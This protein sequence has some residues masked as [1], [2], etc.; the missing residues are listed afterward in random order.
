MWQ[1]V[2]VCW[3]GGRGG[4]VVITLRAYTLAVWRFYP[5]FDRRLCGGLRLRNKSPRACGKLQLYQAVFWFYLFGGGLFTLQ[6]CRLLG[7]CFSLV[8]VECI[9]LYLYSVLISATK[10]YDPVSRNAHIKWN[11]FPL[12]SWASTTARSWQNSQVLTWDR[13]TY[14][15]Y[16]SKP[17]KKMTIII[18]FDSNESDGNDGVADEARFHTINRR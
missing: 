12:V 13:G 14:R 10:R 8:Q 15:E 18:K 7:D 5:N 3:W 2:S 16:S 6:D 9:L 17:L 1:G 11:P 4:G